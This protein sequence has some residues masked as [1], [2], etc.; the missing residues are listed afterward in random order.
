[1]HRGRVKEDRPRAIFAE[2]AKGSKAGRTV[3]FV[4]SRE[5]VAL[6]GR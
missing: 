2:P 4:S 5:A 6:S 1:M 3:R